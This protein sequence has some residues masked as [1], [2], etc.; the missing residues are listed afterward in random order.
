MKSLSF[1]VLPNTS[2]RGVDMSPDE[3]LLSI[4][5]DRGLVCYSRSGEAFTNILFQSAASIV[6]YDC[7]FSP[8][9]ALL[10][11]LEYST[12]GSLISRAYTVS[13]TTIAFLSSTLV[14]SNDGYNQARCAFSPSGNLFAVAHYLSPYITLYS[15]SGNTFTLLS[16]PATLPTAAAVGCAFS[17]DGTKLAVAHS[18]GATIYSVSGTTF[19]KVAEIIGVGA[20]T[21][22]SFSHDNSMLALCGGTS[23]YINIYSISGVTYTELADPDILPAGAAMDCKFD[24]SGKYLAVSHAGFPYFTIYE[25]TGTAF[26]KIENPAAL[27]LSATT[28]CAFSATDDYFAAT[29]GSKIAAYGFTDATPQK[30]TLKSPTSVYVDVSTSQTFEWDHNITT[31]TAQTRA[32]LQYSTDGATWL[33]I[34]TVTGADESVAV[35]AGVLPFGAFQWRARTYNLDSVY[36]EWSDTSPLV[37]IGKPAAPTIDSVTTTPRPVI[38]WQATGQQAYEVAFGTVESGTKFGTV[39]TFKC[40]QYLVNGTYAVKVRIQ[41]S[42]GLWSDWATSSVTVSNTAGNA[43][44]LTVT[45]SHV[46]SLSWTTTGSYDKYYVYR[47]GALIAKTTVKN[48]VDNTSIGSTVYQVRGAYNANDNYGLSGAVTADI[49][50]E[51]V[52]ITGL[53]SISWQTLDKTASSD[54]SNGVSESQKVSYALFAGCTYQSVEISEFK[55]KRISFEAAFTTKASADAFADLLGKLV[56]VKDQWGNT[57]I[58]VL[59]GHSKASGRFYQSFTCEVE[60]IAYYEVINHD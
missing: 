37:G 21:G 50:C 42:N 29:Y 52:M 30:P 19:T 59:A 57:V 46:A 25:V 44:A 55:T 34:A 28:S 35:A 27:P 5:A 15:V 10:I 43:I 4:A 26:A 49:I 60:Q 24:N 8:S 31:A 20:C 56:C 53:T 3:S 54:R 45:A 9:G 51:T 16:N 33:G 7:K 14:S 1:D 6:S 32:D 2:T 48:Y 39:K 38:T 17:P 12:G 13:G 47:N 36:G 11:S 23:P 18:S 58:G 41:N 40:P 22:C